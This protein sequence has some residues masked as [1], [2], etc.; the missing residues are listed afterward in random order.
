MDARVKPA[1]DAEFVWP[2]VYEIRS[3]FQGRFMPETGAFSELA[4][5]Q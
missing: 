4:E 2:M 1:H 5:C 3:R